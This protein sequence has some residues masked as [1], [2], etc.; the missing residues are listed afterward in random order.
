[1]ALS[2]MP[3]RAVDGAAAFFLPDAASPYSY[4]PWIFDARDG[5]TAL[6]LRHHGVHHR[7]AGA[8]STRRSVTICHDASI[9]CHFP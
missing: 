2:A 4:G 7:S 3:A 5:A 1:L 6:L 8:P 9:A